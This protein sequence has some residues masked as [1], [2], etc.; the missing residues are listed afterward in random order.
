M[1]GAKHDM[2]D[3]MSHLASTHYPNS[4]DFHS[5]LFSMMTQGW[6]RHYFGYMRFGT[7]HS[8]KASFAAKL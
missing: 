8:P 4:F 7:K 2:G 5:S 3:A 6:R 1:P